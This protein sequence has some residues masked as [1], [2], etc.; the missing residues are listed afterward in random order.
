[1]NIIKYR[2]ANI[3]D[4]NIYFE[5]LND[6]QV[7]EKSFNV[8]HIKWEDHCEW[9]NDKINDPNYSFYIFQSN[10][11]N[12][13]QV[14]IHKVNKNESEIGISIATKY[15]GQGYGSQMLIEACND[16]FKSSKLIIIN[17]FIKNENISSRKTFEKAGFIFLKNILYNNINTNHY[18]LYA[19]RKL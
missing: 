7:R 11:E 14:R 12:I 10:Q 15:R 19:D 16:Y 18:I 4:I 9:F 8:N 6:P 13:G 1:M 17:A 3:S 5:W 2:K